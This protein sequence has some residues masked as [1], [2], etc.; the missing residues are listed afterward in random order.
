VHRRLC[1][2]GLLAILLLTGPPA[3]PAAGVTVLGIRTGI[4]EGRVRVVIDLDARARYRVWTPT[5]P[6]RIAIDVFDARFARGVRALDLGDELVRRVRIN[7]LSG[8]RAQIVLDLS[9]KARFEVFALPPEG[10]RGHRIVCDVYRSGRPRRQGPSEAP[11]TVVIDPGHGGRD[12]GVVSRRGDR[13]ADICL[14]VARRLARLL[15]AQEGVRAYLTREGDRFLS[16]RQRMERAEA[17]GADAFVSIH[18]NAART[19]KAH[20]A[21]VF[22]LS[23]KGATD[24]ASRELARLENA[25]D[26]A[27]E[28]LGEEEVAEIPFGFDLR[29]S[30][31]L[32]R[33]SL[34]AESLLRALE[35]AGLAASRGVKQAGFMVLKSYRIPSA[36]VE[37]GFMSHPKDLAR[38]RKASYRQKMAEVLARGLLEYRE[39]YAP[40]RNP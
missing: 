11:W 34:L 36:L 27:G 12:P 32:L 33:S 35:K 40:S 21:E 5:D 22:F 10:K 24:T 6:E 15:N 39:S 19:P 29:Q 13:E 17:L 37:M 18:V 30:D 31:T 1:S 16:L 9:R 28:I 20:G 14:D 25:A 7:R 3:T 23:L 2:T 26:R 4:T 38:L 8:P